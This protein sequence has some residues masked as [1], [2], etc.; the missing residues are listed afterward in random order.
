MPAFRL[1][2]TVA[3]KSGAAKLASKAAN[4][5][6][7][8]SGCGNVTGAERRISRTESSAVIGVLLC[9]EGRVG[10]WVGVRWDGAERVLYGMNGEGYQVMNMMVGE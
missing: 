4:V 5:F 8:N 3:M 9:A 6:Q 7:K 10:D 2:V 1:A